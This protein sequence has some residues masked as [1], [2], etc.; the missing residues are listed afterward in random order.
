MIYETVD[1]KDFKNSEAGPQ[2]NDS[3][4]E[5]DGSH[6]SRCVS[7]HVSRTPSS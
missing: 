6:M 7:S 4:T 3:K 5:D 1:I 2:F